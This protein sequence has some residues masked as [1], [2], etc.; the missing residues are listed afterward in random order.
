VCSVDKQGTKKC[1]ARVPAFVESIDNCSLEHQN[2]IRNCVDKMKNEGKPT[3]SP[4]S[5]TSETSSPTL[6]S[7][8][9]CPSL[10]Q[11]L[12]CKVKDTKDCPVHAATCAVCST[13][14]GPKCIFKAPGFTQCSKDQLK[15]VKGCLQDLTMTP[16]PTKKQ[17]SSPTKKHSGDGTLTPSV[18]PTKKRSGTKIP[19]NSPMRSSVTAQPSGSSVP[20]ASPT[21]PVKCPGNSQLTSCKVGV[22]SCGSNGAKCIVCQNHC[23][24]LLKGLDGVSPPPFARCSDEYLSAIQACQD[25]SK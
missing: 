18:A 16:S 21:F 13:S 7:I 9:E 20:T 4:T 10:D 25:T 24:P 17:T 19:T 11:L 12:P 8:S 3:D 2:Y 15:F 14:T 6:P 1:F 23:V 22:S 5:A